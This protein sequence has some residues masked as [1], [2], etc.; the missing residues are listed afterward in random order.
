[1]NQ[2]L[3]AH[4]HPGSE[5]LFPSICNGTCPEDW[6]LLKRIREESAETIFPY[7]GIHPWFLDDYESGWLDLLTEYLNYPETAGV[8]EIGLD[9]ARG[10]IP[11]NLQISVF[12][13]QLEMAV[14]YSLPVEVH[15]VRAFGLCTDILKDIYIPSGLP[16]LIHSFTGSVEVMEQ[17]AAMGGYFSFGPELLLENRDKLRKVF[18]ETPLD[19]VLFETDSDSPDART[20]LLKTVYL[21]GAEL[22]GIDMDALQEIILNN[23]KVFTDRT[24]FGQGQS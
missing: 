7:Y 12:S 15:C 2:L 16:F 9:R 21:K 13:R 22:R 5:F 20:H 1:M 14:E 6:S 18:K 23:G 10:N 17:M 24:A 4:N 3:D 19:R 11:L 8:G